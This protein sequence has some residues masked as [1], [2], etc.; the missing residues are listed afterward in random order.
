MPGACAALDRHA[1][2]GERVDVGGLTLFHR[3]AGPEDGVPAVL[4][5]GLPHSSFLYRRVIPLLAGRRPVRAPDLPGFGLSDKPK[6][7]AACS[8]PAF[9]A[10]L[11]RYFDALKAPRLHLVCHDISG[12]PVASWAAKHP[13]RVASLAVLNTAL[14][15]RGFR[16]P[17]LVAAGIALPWAL[18]RALLD[19]GACARLVWSYARRHAHA[20]P[21]AFDG[22]DGEAFRS[23]F[24]RDGGRRTATW[25][26]KSYWG[27]PAYLARTR[28]ALA[29]FPR[30][31]LL[32]WGARDPFC[33]PDAARRLA[34]VI[35]GS[36]LELV[37]GASH[38]L[39]E[40]A[41]DETARRLNAFWDRA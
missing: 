30:P 24:L 12:P 41:P 40:D 17:G 19:D 10:A 22:E 38:F 33:T 23:L 36:R 34:A 8:L 14:T 4:V 28:A 26:V 7:P 27:A 31:T 20:R 6:D 16:L 29:G 9:E 5:H 37:D 11:G 13:G 18:Q 3:V 39:P 21:E 25:T 1:A 32:L 35:P 2:A 15:L